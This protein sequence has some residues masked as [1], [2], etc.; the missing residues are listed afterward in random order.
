LQGAL[1]G[2]VIVDYRNHFF[3]GLSHALRVA[4]RNRRH[5]HPL[6]RHDTTL[7]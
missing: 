1:N 6:V 4:L 2:L 7:V 5:N 3:C